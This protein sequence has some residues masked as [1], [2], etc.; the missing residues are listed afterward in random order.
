MHISDPRFP[1][2]L[3]SE[4]EKNLVVAS[5]LEDAQFRLDAPAFLSSDKLA[6]FIPN[7]SQSQPLAELADVFTVYIQ[8]PLLAYVDP[9]AESRP[10]LTTSELA[11]FQVRTAPHVS[12]LADRRLLEWEIRRGNIIVSRSGRVGEAYWVDKKLDGALVGDS[13]R[14]VPKTPSDGPFIYAVLASSFARNFLSGSAYGSVVDHASVDQLRTFPMPELAATARSKIS[15]T[16]NKAITAREHAYDLLDEAQTQLLNANHLLPLNPGDGGDASFSVPCT[17]ITQPTASACEFRLEAHYHNP[18]ARAAIASL[19]KSP[20]RKSSL[21]ALSHD[22]II[23]GRSKRNYVGSAYGTPFLSGKNIIQIRPSD[24]KHVSNSETDDLQDM[25]LERGWILVT[26]SGTLGRTCFVWHNYE[27]HAASEHILRVLP[28]EE[29]VDAG[30]LY[31]FLASDH[32]Y[33][34]IVRFRF[35]SVID[36]ISNHQLKQ[37]VVPLP[38]PERQKEIGDLVR[39]AYEKRAEALQ[40]EDEAQEILLNEISG[41]NTNTMR[42]QH[43]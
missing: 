38:S 19:Q 28:D 34:Q 18:A 20:S 26:R 43:V 6:S 16:M 15:S 1:S 21:G 11:E 35:G 30:Y 3:R 39:Q 33:E 10:Y 32:G 12:L 4:V 14:V 37:V 8:S 9:F 40:L 5:R 36:E 41:K 42:R 13:F 24:V 22:V 17:E 2:E 29:R 25:L 27:Q 31:A 7:T 23:G